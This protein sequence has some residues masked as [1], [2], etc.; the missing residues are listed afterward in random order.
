MHYNNT[1]LYRKPTANWNNC[2]FCGNPDNF[3]AFIIFY[4]NTTI[5]YVSEDILFKPVLSR[6]TIFWIQGFFMFKEKNSLF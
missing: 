1:K 3:F 2:S 6:L 5:Y 4:K